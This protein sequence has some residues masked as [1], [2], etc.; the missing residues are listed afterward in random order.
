MISRRIRGFPWVATRTRT[1]LRMSAP[2]EQAARQAE[3]STAFRFLARAG[4]V[5][6]GIVHILIGG[7]VL[8]VAFGGSGETNQSG[9]FQA[10]ASAPLGYV[11][12]W[13]LAVALCAL[14]VW[15]AVH[16][17]AVREPSASKTWGRRISEWGQAVVFAA[18]GVLAASVAL[19]ARPDTE[20]SAEGASQGVLS[21]PGGP[22][23]LGA[24]G[25]AFGIGGVAFVVMGLRRSFHK[26]I[27]LPSG[28]PGKALSLL[29]VVGF[30]AK[31][32][33]LGIVGILLVVAAV[34]FDPQ[35]AGG[36]D[37]AIRALLSVAFGPVLVGVVGGGFIAY[38]VFTVFRAK[39]AR[40]QS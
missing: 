40:L 19:G 16:G 7:I 20:E 26:R 17:F 22:L 14:G 5:A 8:A 34:T 33:A 30:V 15:H 1:L 32:V 9:A 12:L 31:G 25:L 27:A 11:A 21:V 23:L 37:G 2:S 28:P 18:L 36:F 10:I 6:N 3:T 35:A 4:Y 29:G 13:V 39:Y 38:G 24:V